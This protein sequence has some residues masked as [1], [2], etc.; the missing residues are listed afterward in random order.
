MHSMQLIGNTAIPAETDVWGAYGTWGTCE[1]QGFILFIGHLG[2]M[3]WDA[4][5]STVF[6]LMV[7]YGWNEAKLRKVELWM[8]VI[9]WPIAI[10]IPVYPLHNDL[11]GHFETC[12]MDSEPTRCPEGETCEHDSMA[13]LVIA[14]F[15]LSPFVAG[16]YSMYVM[17][18]IYMKVCA[19]A[20]DIRSRNPNPTAVSRRLTKALGWKGILYASTLL[21]G[22]FLVT[23]GAVAYTITQTINIP[24]LAVSYS[25]LGLLGTFNMLVFV[26]RRD[27]MR[28]AYGHKVQGLMNRISTVFKVCRLLGLQTN[29]ETQVEGSTARRENPPRFGGDSS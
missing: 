2:T 10:I 21:F 3:L 22:T 27:T 14:I 24:R 8:H 6:L 15:S 18:S 23:Y 25:I 20:H 7:R 5:L 29:N 9:I 28:T 13:K 12:K 16:I 11:Y 1:A 19:L 17:L 4:A 26:M